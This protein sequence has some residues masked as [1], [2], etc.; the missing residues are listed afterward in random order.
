MTDGKASKCVLEVE[1]IKRRRQQRRAAAEAARE[2]VPD[3]GCINDASQPGYGYD[4]M[5]ASVASHYFSA[6]LIIAPNFL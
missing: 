4:V 2:Q 1:K 6:P 3:A 5:I